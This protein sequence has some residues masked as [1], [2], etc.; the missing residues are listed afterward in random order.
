MKI[1][2]V[3]QYFYP[4]NFRIN[5]IVRE[6]VKRGHKITVVTGLPNYPE[7]KIYDGY[8]DA[9]KK[10]TFYF[11][12]KVYRCKLRPRH[13]GSLNLILNYWSFIR[14]AKKT[15]KTIAPDFDIVYFYEPSPITSGLPVIWY[16][17]KHHIKTAIYNLDIWPDCVRD[18]SR[19]KPMSLKHPVYLF[20]KSLSRRVYKSFD[21]IINKCDEFAAYL[22][23]LFCIEKNKMVTIDEFAE[24][25]YLSVQE[26]PIDNG[27]IDFMFLGNIG[28]SQN[29]D[30]IVE[31]FSTIK[32]D[33]IRLHFV[34]DG[35]YLEELKKLTNSLGLQ[36]RVIFHG[37]HPLEEINDYYNLADVC[38]LT[39]SNKTASGLTPPTKLSGYMAAA[40]CVVASIDGAARR[41]IEESKCGYTCGADD[42]EKLASLMNDIVLNPNI[43]NVLGTNGRRYFLEHFTLAEHVNKLENVFSS[44]LDAK[45]CQR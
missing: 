40:R 8:K 7:G 30:Q 27:L 1:L 33:N 45:I 10:I 44:I 15:L 41:I 20:A 4:E 3:S 21:L 24:D 38:L 6:L 18:L 42:K 29:C 32:A 26:K 16:A 43:I 28:K 5:D 12:A 11:G 13:K 36:D 35:S 9:Y 37:R 2:V 31:A 25:T 23:T 19:G 17:K 14:Q 34:G 22:N 39:L